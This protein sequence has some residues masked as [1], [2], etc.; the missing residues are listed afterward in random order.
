M[1]VAKSAIVYKV[2]DSTTACITRA[3]GK[4]LVVTFLPTYL[5]Q[6]KV[7]SSEDYQADEHLPKSTCYHASGDNIFQDHET[8]DDSHD[9]PIPSVRALYTLYRLLNLL[10]RDE[11]RAA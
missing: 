5:V 4:R 11:G 2:A 6:V 8:A 7:R 3:Y 10:H 9:E 1:V